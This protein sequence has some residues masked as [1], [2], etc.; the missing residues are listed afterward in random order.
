MK[1]MISVFVIGLMCM[2]QS[3]GALRADPVPDAAPDAMGIGGATLLG[4]SFQADLAT[5]AATMTVNIMVPPGRKNMQPQ[6]ALSYS[7]NNSNGICGMGWGIPM[8]SI[9]RSTKDGV[10]GYDETDTMVFI[11]S[12][13][14]A[15]LVPAGDGNY[16]ARIESAFMKYVYD[17]IGTS[18]TVYD[19]T[20]TKYYF[21]Q[22]ASSR[23]EE[24][25]RILGWYIDR[26]E[27]VYGNYIT[28]IYDKPGD[29]QIYLK[30]ID[31]TGG[32]GLD[33]D[34][35][36]VLTY[37]NREDNIYSYRSG[38]EIATTKRLSGIEIHVAQSLVWSYALTYEDSPDT[39]RSLLT[40]V[41][42]SDKDGYSLPAKTFTYQRLEE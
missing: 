13:A 23:A 24:G 32:N 37:K 19:K 31:Y 36:I 21:G 29:G 10:P 30:E 2:A 6:F 4:E 16:R 25:G 41:T 11:S 17:E 18:W 20:G 15:E 27:D 12:G 40:S 34:K 22:D 1:R 42:V 5:G 38:W 7:S 28:Y 8:S 3:Q 9:Q 14:N 35:K 39:G 26:V 33:P